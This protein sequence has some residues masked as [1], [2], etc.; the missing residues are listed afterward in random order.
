MDLHLSLE[1]YMLF[2][3]SHYLS[4]SL[5][6]FNSVQLMTAIIN[7]TTYLNSYLFV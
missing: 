6:L 4:I 5:K 3:I 7:K 2:N 1:H